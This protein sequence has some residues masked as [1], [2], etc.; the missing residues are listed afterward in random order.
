M[1]PHGYGTDNEK[2]GMG[3]E[4]NYPVAGQGHHTRP[5]VGSASIG[6][7]SVGVARSVVERVAVA[8]AAGLQRAC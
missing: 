7:A 8:A 5:R 4:D 1:N 2:A 6:S 3:F